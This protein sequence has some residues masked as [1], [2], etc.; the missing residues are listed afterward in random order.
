MAQVSAVLV[1][2]IGGGGV[3]HGIAFAALIRRLA[4]VGM[5]DLHHVANLFRRAG[6][7]DEFRTEIAHVILQHFRRVTL[8]V[9]R[10]HDHAETLAQVAQPVQRFGNQRQPGGADVRTIGVTEIEQRVPALQIL[11]GERPAVHVDEFE[12]TAEL[13]DPFLLLLRKPGGGIKHSPHQQQPRGHHDPEGSAHSTLSPRLRG[14]GIV[15]RLA[16]L[17]F[18]PFNI[19]CHTDDENGQRDAPAGG[20]AR[21]RQMHMLHVPGDVCYILLA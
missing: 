6:E 4:V 15:L 21:A 5:P 3:I 10:D 1:Q 16:S 8:G 18:R 17:R 14:H 13:H 19:M 7:A 20:K 12:R 11:L 9:D 2:Q